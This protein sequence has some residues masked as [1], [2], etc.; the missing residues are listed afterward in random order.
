MTK[1]DRAQ[2]GWDSQRKRWTVRIQIGEEVIKRRCPKASSS[3]DEQALRELA[4][5]TAQ[6][7]GY[8]LDSTS[9]EI[10]R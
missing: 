4:I 5:Q 9:V 1:A 7:D 8:E 3:I 2:V 6:D 10:D